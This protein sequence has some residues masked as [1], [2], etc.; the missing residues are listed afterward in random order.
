[1]A[2][3]TKSIEENCLLPTDRFGMLDDTYALC[4]ACEL[5]LSSLLSLMD[6]FK[7]EIDYNVLSRLINIS[8]EVLNISSNAIQSSVN[9]LKQFFIN[10]L[11]FSAE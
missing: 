9:D 6:V 11:R 10:I 5:P 1:M 8:Y 2:L 7:K 4:E 3:L